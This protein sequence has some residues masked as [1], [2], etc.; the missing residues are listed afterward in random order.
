MILFSWSLFLMLRSI[1]NINYG[2]DYYKY[3]YGCV[4]MNVSYFIYG[5][6]ISCYYVDFYSIITIL[7]GLI[8]DCSVVNG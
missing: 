2:I 7:L 5:V 6:F 8:I 1:R 4:S 3:L